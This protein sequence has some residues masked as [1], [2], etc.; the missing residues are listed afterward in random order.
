MKANQ[1]KFTLSLVALAVQGALVGVMVAPVQAWAEGDEDVT[2]LTRP[3][4]TIDIGISNTNGDHSDKFGEYSG[5]GLHPDGA[6]NPDIL[7]AF[8]IRG[9][10][11][12]GMDEGTMRWGAFGTDLGLSSRALGAS[13]SNQG[14]W[15]LGI[16]YDELRHYSTDSYQTPFQGNMGGNNFT[17]PSNFGVVNVGNVNA[18]GATKPYGAQALSPTQLGDFTTP[19]VSSDRKNSGFNAGF[20]LNEQWGVQLDINHLAQTGAKLTA[21]GTNGTLNSALTGALAAGSANAFKAEDIAIL[22]NPTDYDTDTVTLAA[23]WKGDKGF[24]T[25]SYYGSFFHDNYNSL[26][27]QSP[28]YNGTAT[29]T[30]VASTPNWTAYPANAIS[31]MPDNLFQQLN[32]NGGYTFNSTTKA[33]GGLS[34]GRNTQNDNYVNT[35][36]AS[37]ASAAGLNAVMMAG[38]LPQ[39]SLNG[40]VVTTHADFKVTN[41]TTKDLT[42]SAVW[43]F[44]ERNNETAS[45]N[46]KYYTI[47]AAPADSINAP[48]SNRKTDLDFNGDYRY[49]AKQNIHIGLETEQIRRWCNN[50][51]STAPINAVLGASTG[52]LLSPTTGNCAQVPENNEYKLVFADRI[53]ASDDLNVTAGYTFSRRGADYN[54]SFYNPMQGVREEGYEHPGFVAYMDA[55]RDENLVKLS[56]NWQASEKLSITFGGKYSRDVYDSV[57]GMQ[58][59]TSWSVNADSTYMLGEKASISA[60]WTIQ[61]KQMNYLSATGNPENS[62][63]TGVSTYNWTNRQNDVDNTFGLGVKQAGLMK[64]KLDLKG[65]L[66]YSMATSGYNTQYVNAPSTVTPCGVT[67]TTGN[68]CGQTPDI[69]NKLVQLKLSGEYETSKSGRIIL[70]YVY[71]HLTSND[72]FYNGYEFTNGSTNYGPTSVLPTGQQA[73]GYSATQVYLVY[74][75]K[76]Q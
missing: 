28:F 5:A 64:G 73:V 27:F 23:N 72:F 46:Y 68:A 9:G 19:T 43:K 50:S 51:L 24:F 63:F 69:S 75:Y 29:T 14:S 39:N 6:F 13:V 32:A 58:D 67:A 48:M 59:G 44:N 56:A 49:S 42:L 12:Y 57:F 11:S 1:R 65:D 26:N 16:N 18:P 36:T 47:G 4:N 21:V 45:S 38:G 55:A 7:G 52:P 31:T 10:N 61:N 22:M 17:L 74:R 66:T 54:A 71:S 30:G 41:Q 25:G 40:L 62:G 70:G 15:S 20:N 76:F 35:T 37:T 3:S 34:Y 60:Y 2:A 8:N 53:K 33:V